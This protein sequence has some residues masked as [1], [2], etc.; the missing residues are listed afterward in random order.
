[1]VSLRYSFVSISLGFLLINGIRATRKWEYEPISVAGISSNDS[2]ISFDIK[3]VRIT[4]GEFGVSG[5]VEWNY[6]ATDETTME[7]VVYRSSSGDESDYKVNNSKANPKLILFFVP[8]VLIQK[9]LS[10]I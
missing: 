7:A 2:L 5:I 6:D 8:F 1:M 9:I 3:I 10:T 4:R